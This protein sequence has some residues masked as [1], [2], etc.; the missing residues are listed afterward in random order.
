MLRSKYNKM[1]ALMP[2]RKLIKNLRVV[3]SS[4]IAQPNFMLQADTYVNVLKQIYDGKTQNG[5]I[6]P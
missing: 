6:L 3:M 5:V 2:I 4:F 1:I